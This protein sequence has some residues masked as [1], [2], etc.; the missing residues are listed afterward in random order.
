[1]RPIQITSGKLNCLHSLNRLA[2]Q[3]DTTREELDD[4]ALTIVMFQAKEADSR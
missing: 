2:W 1:M 4:P 3:L